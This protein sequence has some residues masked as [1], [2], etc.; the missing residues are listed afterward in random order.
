MK[1]EKKHPAIYPREL[2][3]KCLRVADV[4]PNMV[5]YDPFGGTGTTAAVAK[6][7]DCDY[8]TTEIDTDYVKFIKER[9]Q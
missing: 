6:E 9:L 2:V 1:G 3:R 8:I 7:F 5:V 4:Q